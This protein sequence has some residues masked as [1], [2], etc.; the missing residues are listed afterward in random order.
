M[1][2]YLTRGR[3]K[4]SRF[5]VCRQEIRSKRKATGSFLL[6]ASKL[7][8]SSF[9]GAGWTH[10]GK[11]VLT[12]E[13][14]DINRQQYRQVEQCRAVRGDQFHVYVVRKS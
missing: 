11:E 1:L 6:S 4:K 14:Q 5:R 12:A 7:L 3:T 8:E 2:F 9:D 13:T 10:A